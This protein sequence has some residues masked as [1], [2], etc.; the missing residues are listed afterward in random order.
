M[1]RVDGAILLVLLLGGGCVGRGECELNQAAQCRGNAYWR[2]TA[3][4]DQPGRWDKVDCGAHRYCR[5]GTDF[6]GTGGGCMAEPD[7]EPACQ[8]VV[9]RT[10]TACTAD[11]RVV[12]C[13]GGYVLNVV[14]T[15]G[16][17][18]LC[19]SDIPYPTC[20]ASTTLDPRCPSTMTLN[21]VC[22]GDHAV[23]CSSGYLVADEPCGAG[24]CYTPPD[25]HQSPTC[26]ASLTPDPRCPALPPPTTSGRSFA[27][28]GNAVI[29]CID[30][31]YAGSADC[32]TDTCRASGTVAS[33]STGT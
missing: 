1:K 11:G 14:A 17:P 32:G 7:P 23:T 21:T 13:V 24:L 27:C 18:G 28:E 9:P 16:A 4:E 30:G 5:I 33:C 15:C 26:V 2:C 20:V 3:S 8:S 10:G 12:S 19:F 22:M 25:V 29:T 6:R 31:L